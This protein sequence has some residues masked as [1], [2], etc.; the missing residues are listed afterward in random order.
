[1][2]VIDWNDPLNVAPDS[3][4]A[5]LDEGEGGWNS[6]TFTYTQLFTTSTRLYES[7]TDNGDLFEDTSRIKIVIDREENNFSL[8]LIESEQFELFGNP[9]DGYEIVTSY[10]HQHF[11]SLEKSSPDE[12]T[13]YHL[14]SIHE[15]FDK[16]KEMAFMTLD[17]L[18]LAVR[19]MIQ[20]GEESKDI[21][22]VLTVIE[23]IN[24][25]AG[26]DFHD[27]ECITEE[28][29]DRYCKYGDIDQCIDVDTCSTVGNVPSYLLLQH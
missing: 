7:L 9:T 3:S 8:G 2:C 16:E 20:N 6:G 11:F 23:S 13:Y 5:L 26:R 15:P 12:I 25:Y 19:E 10:N 28:N 14:T 18:E 27:D 22:C 4:L 29:G 17:R 1:M 21:L 24:H